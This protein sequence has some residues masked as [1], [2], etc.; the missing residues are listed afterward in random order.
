MIKMA[1]AIAL[2]QIP[3]YFGHYNNH[4]KVVVFAKG[5]FLF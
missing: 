4:L 5:N 1:D 3:E 2:D